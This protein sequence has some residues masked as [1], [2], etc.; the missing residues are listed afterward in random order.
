MQQPYI[1]GLLCKM[2]VKNVLV[3]F[4]YF[5]NLHYSNQLPVSHPEVTLIFA[6][7]L[8]SAPLVHLHA[9]KILAGV[10]SVSYLYPYLQNCIDQLGP[11]IMLFL[12]ERKMGPSNLYVPNIKRRNS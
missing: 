6:T 12:P 9:G 2:A 11:F 3:F 5:T 4:A 1:E 10:A 7:M 8:D